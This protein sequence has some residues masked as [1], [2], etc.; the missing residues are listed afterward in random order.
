MLFAIGRRHQ[1]S[2]ILTAGFGGRITEQALRGAREGLNTPGGINDDHGVWNGVQNGLK[3]L[4]SRLDGRNGELDLLTTDSQTLPE[5][6]SGQT[7]PHERNRLP[8]ERRLTF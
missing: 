5:R 3:A 6:R 7:D 1:H 4:L 2:D 8:D